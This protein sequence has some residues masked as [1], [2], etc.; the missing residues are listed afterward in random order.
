MTLLTSVARSQNENIFSYT[1][2]V[3]V[4]A[5][6]SECAILQQKFKKNFQRYCRQTPM[7]G[8]GYGTPPQALSPRHS[9]AL[10]LPRLDRPSQNGEIKSWQPS[11]WVIIIKLCLLLSP[12]RQLDHE[13]FTSADLLL[14][15]Q[16]CWLCRSYRMLKLKA[17]HS[18]LR[19]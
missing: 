12:F 5:N 18:P 8:R 4:Y 16:M 10:R 14:D 13:F 1:D 17:G 11:S 6:A 3:V 2:S 7:L 19:P 15:E 9:G